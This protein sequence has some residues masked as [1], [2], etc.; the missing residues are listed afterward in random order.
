[1][2]IK[3]FLFLMTLVLFR[4]VG[5]PHLESIKVLRDLNRAFQTELNVFIDFKDF[6]G[7]NLLH[8][9]DTP[10]ILLTSSSREAK[11]LRIRG[12]F[13]ERALI[14][15][16]SSDSGLDPKVANLLPH[17]LNKLHELHI[18]FLSVEK[19]A[20]S[21]EELYTYCFKEGFVNVI[22]ICGKDLFSYL[23]YPTIQPVKLVNISEYLNRGRIIRNF[24]GHPVRTLR[25][26]LA[27][28][29]FEYFNDKNELVRAG[30]LFMAVKELT[31]RYNATLESVP[32][33]DVSEYE[34]YEVIMNMLFTKKIDIICYFKDFR[35]DVSY[36]APLSIIPEYFMVPHARPISSYLYYSRPFSW[37]LWLVVIS[38]VFYGTL[39][40]YLTSG[41]ARN[42]IGECLLH[43]LSH[44]LY[45]CHQNIRTSGWRDIAIHVILTIGGFVLTNIYLAT[46]S[47]ILTSGLYEG[48]YNTLEELARAP[49][50]SLH[51]EF[52]K[53]QLQSNAF[54]P[55]ALRRNSMTLNPTLLKAYRDGLNTSYIYLLYEDRLEL[56]LMQQYLLK[57]PRFN[58]IRQG[59]GYALESYCVSNSLPY[60]EMTSEFMR[61]LQEHGINIKMKADTFRELIQQGIYTLMRDDEPP[62]KAFDLDYYFFAFVL[63]AVGLVVSLLVFFVEV[64]KFK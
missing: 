43:S 62:A 16:Q 8:S 18:V 63:W 11:D 17:L 24:K 35:W 9:L 47:S 45:N 13:T 7:L 20:F 28:R 59:V 51:D 58:M 36:T 27:P 60:L 50:P 21:K 42:E 10:R 3:M 41:G 44:I 37:T 64:F 56:I 49:Y 22:L 6:G 31:Y 14:L 34:S 33:P 4:L 29:D 40:L 54:V 15:V 46:L 23:P 30:Y 1:M 57:T 38:T 55:E 25:T 52:Y 5:A 48:E 2:S 12:N 26:T 32:L 39:M 19:P 53:K 61:R